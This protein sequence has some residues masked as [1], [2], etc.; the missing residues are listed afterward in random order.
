MTESD[1]VYSFISIKHIDFAKLNNS[2]PNVLA[3]FL[4]PTPFGPMQAD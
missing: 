1:S 3:N 2:N 4:L